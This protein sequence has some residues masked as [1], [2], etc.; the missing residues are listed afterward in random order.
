MGGKSWQKEVIPATAEHVLEALFKNGIASFY[1]AGGTAL[2]LHMGHRLSRDL[3]FFSTQSFDEDRMLQ[4]LKTIEKVSLIAK[5]RET[6]H[7]HISGV[8]VSFLGY[9]YPVLFSFES[10]LGVHVADPRDIACMKINAI[11][12]RGVRRDFVDLYVIAKE[13]GL[14]PLLE[15]FKV[16]Y[17]EV[18]FN[19]IHALKSLTYFEDAEREPMPKM[20]APISWDQVTEFFRCEAPKL[21]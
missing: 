19:L 4:D 10:F 8:K 11:A 21:I 3:D 16:K 1:L 7:L 18:D 2:A 12:G 15:L 14:A 17:A 5:D 6:L 20:L 9:H 13:Y